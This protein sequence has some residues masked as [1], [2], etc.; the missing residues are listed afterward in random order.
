MPLV[1]YISS[2]ADI[3]DGQRYVL[4]EYGVGGQKRHPLGI[5]ITVPRNQS[6]TISDLSFLANV[7]SAKALA[8]QEGISAIFACK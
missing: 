7:H 5:T 2:P 6:K 3:P 8:K 4:V 1:K